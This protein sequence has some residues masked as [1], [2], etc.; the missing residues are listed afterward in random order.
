MTCDVLGV[1]SLASFL[2]V[3]FNSTDGFLLSEWEQMAENI[4]RFLALTSDREHF[5][6]QSNAKEG[7]ARRPGPPAPRPRFC[8][9]DGRHRLKPPVDTVQGVDGRRTS[10]G[11]LQPETKNE[12]HRGGLLLLLLL[13]L[14]ASS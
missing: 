12:L 11:V 6:G 10:E 4:C 9:S 7:A 13:L 14:L 5:Q 2:A 1:G 8:P 3:Y